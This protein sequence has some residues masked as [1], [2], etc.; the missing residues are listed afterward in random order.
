[1]EGEVPIARVKQSRGLTWYMS[2]PA[3]PTLLMLPSAAI[4]GRAGDDVI[5]TLLVAALILPL[6]LLLLRKLATA[7]LSQRT[8]R[9]DLWL[10]AALAFGSV[11]FFSAVQGKVW[12]TAQ[13]VGD[14]LALVYA[15]ASIGAERAIVAGIAL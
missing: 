4:S 15:W 10:V 13:V 3:L 14:A 12:Y 2:F 9:E 11:L 8:L 5:P 1:G 6:T 7:E